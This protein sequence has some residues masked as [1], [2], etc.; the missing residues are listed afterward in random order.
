MVDMSRLKAEAVVAEAAAEEAAAGHRQKI[1]RRKTIGV[2][3]AGGSPKQLI[4][5]V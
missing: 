5:W 1:H 3:W 4:S 2:R